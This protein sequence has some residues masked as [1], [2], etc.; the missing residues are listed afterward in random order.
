LSCCLDVLS[1][2][3]GGVEI[4]NCYCGTICFSLQFCQCLLHVF[5]SSDVWYA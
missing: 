1:T 5:W 2:T 4:S 3:E